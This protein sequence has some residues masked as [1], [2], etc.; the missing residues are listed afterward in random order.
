MANASGGVDKNEDYL[1]AM[2]RELLEETSI[3][4]IKVIKEINN[5]L[6]MSYQRSYWVLYGKVN[7]EVKDKDGL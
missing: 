5:F 3:V 6:N 1:T 4:N 7:L 2:K